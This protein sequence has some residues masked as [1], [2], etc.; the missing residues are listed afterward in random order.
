MR[1]TF[2]TALLSLSFV[3]SHVFAGPIRVCREVPNPSGDGTFLT[4]DAAAVEDPPSPAFTDTFA[5]NNWTTPLWPYFGGPGRTLI[6]PPLIVG[7]HEVGE[8]VQLVSGTGGFWSD[9]GY[10]VHN[11]SQS[12]LITRRR[13]TIRWYS[14]SGSL[15]HTYTLISTFSTPL[16]PGESALIFTGPESYLGLNYLLPESFLFTI[17]FSDFTSYNGDNA[18][19]LTGGPITDGSSSNFAFDR[20][21]GQN[22]D[23]GNQYSNIMFYIRTQPIPSPSCASLLTASSLLTLRRR[24]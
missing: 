9:R 23:L 4:V 12:E 2:M 3:S 6:G 13:T 15:L 11:G 20:T 21:S 24:R 19:V 10:S 16:L 18:G 1:L 7:S 5:W 22:I 8:D 17:Q 14:T